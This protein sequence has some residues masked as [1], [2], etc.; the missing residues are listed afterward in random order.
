MARKKT[1]EEKLAVLEKLEQTAERDLAF[2]GEVRAKTDAVLRDCDADA[3]IGLRSLFEDPVSK[4]ILTRSSDLL[5]LSDM[6]T[7]AGREKELG[8]PLFIRRA[9][10]FDELL[11]LYDKTT[12]FLRR[13][14]FDLE[15]D[16]EEAKALLR[17]SAVS[18]YAVS[19]ILYSIVSHLGRREHILMQLAE[20][21]LAHNMFVEAYGFLN[22]VEQPSPDC[23]SLKEELLHVLENGP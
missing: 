12:L 16:G 8:F 7:A 2:I 15:E 17:E 13:L 18:P 23:V 4:E 21:A 19:A 5:K 1:P 6:I 22:V 20:D 9:G 14:E 11:D 10:T 3:F